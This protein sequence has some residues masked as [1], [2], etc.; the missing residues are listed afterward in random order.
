MDLSRKSVTEDEEKSHDFFRRNDSAAGESGRSTTCRVTLVTSCTACYEPGP[1]CV[2]V[3]RE[4]ASV[5]GYGFVY[6]EGDPRSPMEGGDPRDRARW[7]RAPKGEERHPTWRK[8]EL[9][10]RLLDGLTLPQEQQGHRGAEDLAELGC[11]SDTTHLMWID[12]DAIVVRPE[13]KV[14]GVIA[15]V[16]ASTELVI[17][18]DLTLNGLINAGVM[19]VRVSDWSRELWSDVWSSPLSE[20]FRQ[21][22]YHEQSALMR[23]LMERREGLRQ[24]KPFHSFAQGGPQGPKLFR[25]VAVLPRRMLNTNKGD[26][27]EVDF[28]FHAAGRLKEMGG[29]IQALKTMLAACSPRTQ[30]QQEEELERA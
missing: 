15:R 7:K 13:V 27:D 6:V 11:P 19:I 8:V 20:R 18:E 22:I 16:P 17:G 2:G 24:L 5:H 25:H 30:Q 9:L 12:A 29:K 4:Y 1:L 28:V 10:C 14:E 21:G 23:Q 3:N 26:P